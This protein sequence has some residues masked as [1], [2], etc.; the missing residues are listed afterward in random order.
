MNLLHALAASLFV[1][2]C[3]PSAP[4]VAWTLPTIVGTCHMRE[5]ALAHRVP[6][7][8]TSAVRAAAVR[9]RDDLRRE[10]SRVDEAFVRSME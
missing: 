8:V 2:T 6:E 9:A 4:S 1:S 7:R 5:L 3:V 10:W